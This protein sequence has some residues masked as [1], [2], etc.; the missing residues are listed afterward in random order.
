MSG[1]LALKLVVIGIIAFGFALYDVASN[2]VNSFLL[3]RPYGQVAVVIILTI[4]A[5][6]TFFFLILPVWAKIKRTL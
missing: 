4:V 3:M 1:S 6:L 5:V 2:D